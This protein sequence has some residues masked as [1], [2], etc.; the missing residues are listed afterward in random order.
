MCGHWCGKSQTG[1]KQ[2]SVAHHSVC[3]CVCVWKVMTCLSA[4]FHGPK[5]N[6]A[7]ARSLPVSVSDHHHWG[8]WERLHSSSF[9]S[10]T[11]HAL[12]AKFVFWGLPESVGG[13]QLIA[14]L[15][16]H[17]LQRK[18]PSDFFS[19]TGCANFKPYFDKK[20]WVSTS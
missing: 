6:A 2:G 4:A 1:L 14:P 3:L 12:V 19:F 17:Q 20:E 5:G 13:E 16:I 10:V 9:I 11:N 15:N 7:A 8:F 18:M